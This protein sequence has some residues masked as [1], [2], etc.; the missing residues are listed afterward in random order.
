MEPESRQIKKIPLALVDD[1]P[2]AIRTSM[3][4]EALN[5]L[6]ESIRANGLIQPIVVKQINGRYEVVVGHRRL[7]AHR[8][9]EATEIEAIVREYTDQQAESTKLHENIFREE[10]NPVDEAM[11]LA[12]YIKNTNSKLED[13]AAMLHRSIEWVSARLEILNYPDYMIDEVYHGRLAL[14]SARALAQIEDEKIK[15]EYTRFAVLQGINITTAKRW[16]EK[17]KQGGLPENPANL[18]EGQ[19]YYATPVEGFVAKCAIC[20]QDG[21]MIEMES[22]LL[23]A[24]CR[25]ALAME[26]A[27]AHRNA[28]APATVPTTPL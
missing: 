22:D 14:G 16:L 12:R 15:K 21:Q 7:Q 8:M 23:H 19:D 13:V 24:E 2:E 28:P 27:N 17:S 3:N 5:D 6:V 25:R 9:L 1:P 4:T 10:V 18:P 11:F 20:Q 26:I